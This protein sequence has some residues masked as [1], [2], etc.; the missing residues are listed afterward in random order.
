MHLT[1]ADEPKLT[2][3][4]TDKH[5]PRYASLKMLIPDPALNKLLKLN[6]L[7]IE[8]NCKIEVASPILVA[9]LILKEDPM[10]IRSRIDIEPPNLASFKILKLDPSL[11]TARRERV[12]PRVL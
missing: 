5:P 6:E 9:P 4:S 8:Q 10:S 11:A 12:E 2:M 3:S 1:E 7:P